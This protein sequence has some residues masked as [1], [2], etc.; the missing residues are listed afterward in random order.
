MEDDIELRI[1]VAG[2]E[3]LEAAES[4]AGES[5]NLRMRASMGA[6]SEGFEGQVEPVTLI[7][8]AAG[9]TAVV[10][11]VMDWWDRRRGGLVIDQRPG[12]ADD[13]YRDPDVSFGFVLVF[14]PDGGTVKLE[15]R[16]APKDAMERLLGMVISGGMNTFADVTKAATE[17]LGGA[18]VQAAAGT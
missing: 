14:P 12:R 9:V 3:D 5:T 11:F 13:I 4:I 18:K 1:R 10:K 7:L 17:A 8:I 15:T 2:D 16:D 6:P